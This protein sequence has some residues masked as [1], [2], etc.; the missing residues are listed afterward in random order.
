MV[1]VGVV[2]WGTIVVVD[3]VYCGVG[4]LEFVQYRLASVENLF[5]YRDEILIFE[6]AAKYLIHF[7]R[8]LGVCHVQECRQF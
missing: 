3:P 1:S 5:L 7:L 8:Q 6:L 2:F 4:A